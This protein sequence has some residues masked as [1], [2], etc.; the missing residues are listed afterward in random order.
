VAEDAMPILL[1][2]L[3]P[4]D[5]GLMRA[6]NDL[7]GVVF[8]DIESYHRKRPSAAY[9][10]RLLGS[11][12]FIALVALDDGAV[13][14]GLC[15]YVLQKFEQ[16]RAEVYIYDLAVAPTHRRRGLATALI[17]ALQARAAALG[18]WVIFVQADQGEE[19]APAIA[20]YEKLGL[21]E[22]VLHFDLPVPVQS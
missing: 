2:A 6:L 5:L 17:G 14:G 8:D 13:V 18:A 22:E 12:S 20:L 21:R 19:D 7:Y 10:E 16:E 4:A 1:Q 9:L 3:G 11:D 15:A